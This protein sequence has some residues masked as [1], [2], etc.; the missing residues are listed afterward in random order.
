MG[1]NVVHMYGNIFM[2][3]LEEP[4]ILCTYYFECVLRVLR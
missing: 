3:A 1:L 2:A 4:H